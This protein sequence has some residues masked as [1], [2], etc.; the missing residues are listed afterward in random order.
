MNP[1]LVYILAQ[2]AKKKPL[3]TME[4][5]RVR[6]GQLP[7]DTRDRFSTPGR[8]PVTVVRKPTRTFTPNTNIRSTVI[9]PIGTTFSV[10]SPTTGTTATRQF[11]QK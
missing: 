11:Y 10:R 6:T 2:F 4:N 8:R 3:R 7:F 9:Q 1:I 5:T